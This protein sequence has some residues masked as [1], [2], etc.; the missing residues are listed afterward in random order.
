MCERCGDKEANNRCDKCEIDM[1]DEC[2]EILH[3]IGVF[4][5]HQI[6]MIYQSSTLSSDSDEMKVKY[7]SDLEYC[8]S[9]PD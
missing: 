7:L 9:H 3:T 1:C 4:S 6:K 8:E 2:K 5:K